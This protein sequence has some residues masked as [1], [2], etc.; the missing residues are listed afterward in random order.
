MCLTTQTHRNG[1]ESIHGAH[2]EV[3]LVAGQVRMVWTHCWLRAPW[4]GC[5]EPVLNRKRSLTTYC[6]IKRT[7][8]NIYSYYR[9]VSQTHLR[10]VLAQFRDMFLSYILREFLSSFLIRT[11]NKRIQRMIIIYTGTK[12]KPLPYSLYF[13][14]ITTF[15]GVILILFF[16]SLGS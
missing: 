7:K 6:R 13:A 12:F 16:Q 5:L 1:C 9:Q 10:L 8:M 15:S 4:G 11:A 3:L 2:H 14:V